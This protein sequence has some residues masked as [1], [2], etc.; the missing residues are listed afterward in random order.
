MT[1]KIFNFSFIT[2]VVVILASLVLIIGVLFNFFEG[3]L[4]RELASE[5]E[6]ISFALEGNERG[7]FKKFSSDDKRI[8]LISKDGKVIAD[9]EADPSKMGNHSDREEFA[10]AEKFGT[11]T[12]VR[13]SNTLTE[14]TV[15]YAKKLEN[16]DVLRV[17]TTQYTIVTIIL[18]LMQPIFVIL[19]IAL[20]LSAL[21]SSKATKKIVTPINAIDL[22]NPEESEAYDELAPLLGKIVSLKKKLNEQITSA[23]Q[24]R[25]EFRLITE[26]M[27]EGFLVTDKDENLLSYNSAALK[28]L[29]TEKCEGNVLTLNRSQ[30]F[31][32][33]VSSALKEIRCEN[34]ME[35]GEKILSIIANPV[36]ESGNIVG[37]VIVIIDITE[38]AKREKIRREFTANVSHELKTPLTSISGFAELMKDRSPDADTVKDFSGTI[39]AEAQRLITLVSDII[40]ISE[41]DEE[42]EHFKKENVD[43]YSLSKNIIERLKP[44][45][46]KKKIRFNLEGKST[47]VFGSKEILDEMIYNLCDNAVKYNKEN[48]NADVIIES[49][50]GKVYVSVKDTG[51][52][53]DPSYRDRVFERF[54]RV[55]KS[56][57][58]A[59]GGT[60][61]GLSIVK[62]GA[63]YHSAQIKLDSTVN[64]GTTITIIFDKTK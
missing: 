62:H 38:N 61:L 54:F 39:Y 64:K 35:H 7:F 41:L 12:S 9:N 18:G 43:I 47:F 25:E 11:G 27:N 17:S 14:K 56:R 48:G 57:S 21:L 50:N 52:G 51:I 37:A 53:I 1:K 16:G 10:E 19:L 5:T 29:G 44:E 8:T 32:D 3:Q 22:E 28:L 30:K 59:V 26:N 23:N 55:D 49:D 63:I 2:S 24:M 60:G 46:D 34:T 58:K 31:R 33:S 40:K 13:Y 6:Y 20:L 42:G 4:K 15:Y 36:M 45:A